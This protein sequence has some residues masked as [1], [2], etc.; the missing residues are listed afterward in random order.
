M[1]VACD[2]I[3]AEPHGALPEF[4]AELDVVGYNYVGRWRDRRE[5]YYSIDR[6]D[7]PKRR[8][9]GTENGAMPSFIPGE[10]TAHRVRARV[11]PAHRGR[12]IAAI[13]PGLRLRERRLHVDRN[14]LPRRGSMAVQVVALRGDRQ[15]RISQGRL[16][17]LQEPLDQGA[18]PA[19][20]AALELGRERK[21]RLFR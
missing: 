6:H 5:K 11:K 18:R 10:S 9:I 21:A 16:L 1:T 8:F 17:L 7:F 2:Q 19:P 4:L 15:L 12:A 20:F 3:V 13:H 14:R